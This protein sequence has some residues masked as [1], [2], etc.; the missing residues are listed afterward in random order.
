VS[1]SSLAIVQAVLR[2]L[3]VDIP[4]EPLVLEMGFVVVVVA[5]RL[6]ESTK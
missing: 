1:E 3:V 2:C 6:E 4:A 5:D